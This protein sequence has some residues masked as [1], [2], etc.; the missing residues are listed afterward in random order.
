MT[1][2]K[3]PLTKTEVT[4]TLAERTGLTKQQVNDFFEQFAKLIG[5]NLS[6]SGPGVLNISGLMK[7]KVTR[8]EAVPERQGPHPFTGE[9]TTFAAKPARNVVKVT[10]LKKLKDIVGPPA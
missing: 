3:K 1:D 8:K 6:E 4:S 7:F 9:M 10:A 5:E 2:T